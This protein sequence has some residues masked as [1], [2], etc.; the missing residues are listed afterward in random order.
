MGIYK[1]N[2]IDIFERMPCVEHYD[3]FFAWG[4]Q[5]AWRVVS[6]KVRIKTGKCEQISLVISVVQGSLISWF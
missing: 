3:F 1:F 5:E 4:N 2:L 6:T